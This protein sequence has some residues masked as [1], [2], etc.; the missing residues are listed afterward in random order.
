M[1]QSGRESEL[2]LLLDLPFISISSLA[3]SFHKLALIFTSYG[4]GSLFI[5]SVAVFSAE[6]FGATQL[7]ACFPSLLLV[8]IISNRVLCCGR[9]ID[10]VSWTAEAS[11]T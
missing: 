7:Q 1:D 2:A 10:L 11:E 5:V 8:I 3:A 6:A 4:F 9:E